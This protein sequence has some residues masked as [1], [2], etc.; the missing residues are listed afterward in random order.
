MLRIETISDQPRW[1]TLELIGDLAQ[2]YVPELENLIGQA[3]GRRQQVVLD[4][5]NVG[6]VDR[7]AL[8]YLV[9]AK[10][11]GVRLAQCPPYVAAWI[12]Q[13]MKTG[14]DREPK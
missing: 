12:G 9:R 14:Q 10:K 1:I 6:L 5:R 8:R 4:L 7:E 13:E 2:D 11:E 3:R